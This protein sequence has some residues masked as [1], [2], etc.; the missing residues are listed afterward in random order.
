[1]AETLTAAGSRFAVD[2]A[3]ARAALEQTVPKLVALVRSIRR[4]D[5]HA[6]GVWSAADVAV[7][8]ANAWELLPALAREERTSPL[9]QIDGLAAVTQD[10][11]R[12]QRTTDMNA[13][14]DRIDT[15]ARAFFAQLS[16]QSPDQS[17]PWLVAGLRASLCTFTCH[18]L[19]ES[20]VHGFDIARAQRAP[21][22]IDP[23]HAAL[24]FYGFLLRQLA[25]LDPRAMVVQERASGLRARVEIRLRGHGRFHLALDDG[26]LTVEDDPRGAV[27]CH[28]SAE[29]AA[30]FLVVW[31]RTGQ[32]QPLLRGK[33]VG[34]GRRPLLGMR[35]PSL[36]RSP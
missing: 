3:Q 27:D 22:T 9:G 11:V 24:V 4:P 5:A 30:L 12:D 23:D 26:A 29:P 2:P 34:W 21:W 1:M 33:L 36:L 28:L 16:S 14:A 10:L 31:G 17:G 15:A 8:L 6:V 32:W 13:T 19:N 18:L 20:L 7:H 25:E 35:L